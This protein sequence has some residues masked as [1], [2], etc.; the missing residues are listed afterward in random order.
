MSILRDGTSDEAGF[1]PQGIELIRKRAAEWVEDGRRTRSVVLLAAR[2]GVIA[3]HDAFGALTHEPDSPPLE[4]DSLFGVGSLSKPVTATAVMMLVEDGL[5][6]LNRPLVEYMP[7]FCGKGVEQILVHHLLTHTSGIHGDRAVEFVNE[8]LGD[9]LHLPPFEANQHKRVHLLLNALYP[10]DLW[11]RPGEEMSYSNLGYLVLGELVRRVSGRAFEDFVQ[12]RIFEPLGMVDSSFRFNPDHAVRFVKR[13]PGIPW[14]SDD[15]GGGFDN[16][17]ALDVPHG[18]GGLNSTARDLAA[19]C[20]MF[21]NEGTYGAT[22]VLSR[23]S[24]IEMTRNQIPGVGCEFLDGWHDEA[25]WGLGWSIQGNE[26]WRYY[27]GSLPSIGSYNHG[28]AG[29]CFI[30]VDPEHELVAV[31]LSVCPNIDPESG[32]H[33]W[34]CDTF[35]DLVIA[36]V[37][38]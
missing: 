38:R 6:S 1:R 27:H 23:A 36:A 15:E 14:G 28:G 17:R 37:E 31:Y 10:I 5:L 2:R 22:R 26:R 19:F 9:R 13:G 30:M 35:Q 11:K 20:Q 12:Q 32:E 16:P 8:R 33:H 21:L 7:E 29:G 24:V 34:D 18:G 3:L 4:V 25:S